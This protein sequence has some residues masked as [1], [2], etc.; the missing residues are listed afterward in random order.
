M[1]GDGQ[2]VGCCGFGRR[3]K[4]GPFQQT[5]VIIRHSERVDHMDPAG[6]LA[7][8]EGKEWPFDTPITEGRGVDIA[9]NVAQEMLDLHKTAKFGMIACSPYRRCMQTAAE[10][11][12]LLHLPVALD[13]EVG[14]VWEENFPKESP[15][16]RSPVQLQELASSLGLNV[17]NPVLPEGGLKLFGKHGTWPETIEQ[18]HKR[19]IVRVETYIEQSVT[20]RMNYI[21]ISHAAAVAAMFDLFQRGQCDVQKLEYC[22]RVIATRTVPNTLQEDSG[23]VYV[24]QWDV[25]SKGV[26]MQ[27]SLDATEEA[28]INLCD[29]TRAQG[30]KRKEK[31]TKTDMV[32]DRTLVDLLSKADSTGSDG[33]VRE[34][35]SPSSA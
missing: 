6:Y 31:R 18:G 30:T 14:E 26:D 27:I 25:D 24:E 35:D 11:A 10:V 9:K 3:K 19:C 21:I 1:P 16:H 17:V 7:S 15:P 29:E 32:F 33:A 5:I 8:A 4:G 34:A 20:N 28:H 12:K 13:E 2:K 22:A 23:S